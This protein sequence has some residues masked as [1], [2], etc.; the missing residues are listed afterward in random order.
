M[1]KKN[2]KIFEI[3][4]KEIDE[5]QDAIFEYFLI[6][7]ELMGKTDIEIE[8]ITLNCDSTKITVE[9]YEISP[10]ESEESTEDDFEWI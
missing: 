2:K 10:L 6:I 1:S 7:S 5:M 9:G 8:K 4:V 3:D